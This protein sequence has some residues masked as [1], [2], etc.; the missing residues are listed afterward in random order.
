MM[1]SSSAQRGFDILQ[2]TLEIVSRLMDRWS[3]IT[4]HTTLFH[5]PHYLA[6]TP[7]KKKEEKQ[8]M[9]AFLV[10]FFQKEE[11][12]MITVTQQINQKIQMR[13]QL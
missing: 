3:G 4:Y 8:I 9:C 6:S 7:G 10:F 12:A 5:P 1:D 11:N 2:G 13:M